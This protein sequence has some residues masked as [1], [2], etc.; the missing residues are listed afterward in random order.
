[1]ES[2]ITCLWAALLVNDPAPTFEEV[3]KWCDDIPLADLNDRIAEPLG[4]AI[5]E[6]T[7]TPEDDTKKKKAKKKK[8]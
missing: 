2:F 3:D 7:E 6:G 8:R 5:S 1:M 4:K